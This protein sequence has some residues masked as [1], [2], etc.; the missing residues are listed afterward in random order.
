MDRPRP[1]GLGRESQ[2]ELAGKVI[3]N[4]WT[5]KRWR[6]ARVLVID[7]VGSCP[8]LLA[9]RPGL[10]VSMLDNVLFEKLEYIARQARNVNEP[11]GGLQLILAGDF[12]QLPPVGVS[13][14]G[15]SGGGALTFCFKSGECAQDGE[16]AEADHASPSALWGR[17]VQESI[18]LDRVFRQRDDRF[19]AFLNNIRR[20]G[21]VAGTGGG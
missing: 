5:L 14:R 9:H 11:F 18:V 8:L 19:I 6:H 7:E 2:R 20:G 15:S 21:C 10:Q 16:S 4:R 3:R 1:T 17:V 12:F 13:D